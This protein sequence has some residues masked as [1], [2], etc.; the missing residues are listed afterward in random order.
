MAKQQVS[1]LGKGIWNLPIDDEE[2]MKNIREHGNALLTFEYQQAYDKLPDDQKEEG[3]PYIQAI[4][5]EREGR[6]LEIVRGGKRVG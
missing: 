3:I 6:K 2:R 4:F 1:Y 5:E